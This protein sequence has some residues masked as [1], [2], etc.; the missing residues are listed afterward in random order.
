MSDPGNSA[1]Q[2]QQPDEWGPPEQHGWTQPDQHG[3][4]QP[5]W[6]QP[7]SQPANFGPQ[8][9][10]QQYPTQQYPPSQPYGQ[11]PYPGQQQPGYQQP[12]YPP[13]GYGQPANGQPAYGQSPYGQPA[14]GQP[15]SYGWPTPPPSKQRRRLPWLIGAGLVG[16]VAIV[17]ALIAAGVSG[18][19]SGNQQ[20]SGNSGGGQK[21]GGRS[22]TVPDSF[23]NYS[24]Q[25]DPTADQLADDI[26]NSM[27]ARSPGG[28]SAYAKARIGV[29]RPVGDRPDQLLLIGL[30]AT[31]DPAIAR[32]L[33][34][35]PATVISGM[36][37]GAGVSSAG[38]YDAGPLGGTLRCGESGPGVP[39]CGWADRSTFAMVVLTQ[40][41]DLPQAARVTLQL[42]TAAEH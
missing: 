28:A 16:V 7:P 33:Q 36:M 27:S 40:G 39:I 30:A 17:A 22:L 5:E 8:Y 4:T 12:G 10:T 13:A 35:S 41:T 38:S 34:A 15:G 32:A 42:R 24:R 31:D 37:L 26:R 18:S 29:Y 11:P 25:S 21:G 9:P 19:K 2:P 14:Y 1:N 23:A 6:R 3:W 20:A